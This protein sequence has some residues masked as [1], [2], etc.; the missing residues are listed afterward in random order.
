[1][2]KVKN[3]FGN[4]WEPLKKKASEIVTRNASGRQFVQKGS[5]TWL[6]T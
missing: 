3:K 6:G 4:Y 1:M 5:F 2:N